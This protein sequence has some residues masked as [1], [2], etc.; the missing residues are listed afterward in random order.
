MHLC[1][2]NFTIDTKT[3]VRMCFTAQM[4]HRSVLNFHCD[5]T[6]LM[7]LATCSCICVLVSGLDNDKDLVAD[8]LWIVNAGMDSGLATS[9]VGVLVTGLDNDKDLEI[10]M[11]LSKSQ[12]LF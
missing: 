12:R 10:T 4:K 8:V 1:Y 9:R 3:N 7:S 5:S 11:Q 6:E 2:D